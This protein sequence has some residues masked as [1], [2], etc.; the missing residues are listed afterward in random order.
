MK[1]P[2]P[3][4]VK[5]QADFLK[6]M[7][8]IYAD[9]VGISR[10]KN[11]DYANADNPFQNFKVAEVFGIPVETAI[12]VRMSDKMSRISNLVNRPA[13]VKDESVYDSLRDLANYAVI[14]CMYLENK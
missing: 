7:A 12:I 11:S 4:K 14:L 8:E 3:T 9:N 5:S 6:R 1:P 2:P 13:Q 10:R